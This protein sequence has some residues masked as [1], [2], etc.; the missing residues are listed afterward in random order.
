MTRIAK[1]SM[2]NVNG[3]MYQIPNTSIILAETNGEKA[4]IKLDEK[5][6]SI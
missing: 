1:V 2:I 5:K 6:Y 3:K 4:L